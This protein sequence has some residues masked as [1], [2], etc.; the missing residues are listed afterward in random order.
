LTVATGIW[1]A[2][3]LEHEMNRAVNSKVD[4]MYLPV[5]AEKIAQPQPKSNQ[6]SPGRAQP[7]C[8]RGLAAILNFSAD[9]LV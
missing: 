1:S 5:M 3:F 7:Y 2:G 6:S 8:C 4:I 9:L